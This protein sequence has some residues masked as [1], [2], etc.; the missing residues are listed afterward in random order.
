MQHNILR[1]SLVE[2]VVPRFA[3]EADADV[4]RPSRHNPRPPLLMHPLAGI[5]LPSSELSCT[6]CRPPPLKLC[7]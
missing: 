3:A 5:T 1:K 4:S 6:L 2:N 7:E